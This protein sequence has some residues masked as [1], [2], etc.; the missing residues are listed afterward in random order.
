LAFG[1]ARHLGHSTDVARTLA[2]VGLTVGNLWLVVLSL[3]QGVGWRAWAEP[4]VRA[5][6]AVAVITLLAVVLGIVWA[7]ARTPLHFETPP[8]EG[9]AV[10]ALAV[11]GALSAAAWAMAALLPH[12]HRPHPP[13]A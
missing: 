11:V 4:G 2:V 9:L 5:F 10:T 1:V 8:L 12:P 13:S 6:A 7:P 3:T